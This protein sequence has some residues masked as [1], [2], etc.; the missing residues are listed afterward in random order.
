MNKNTIPLY[1]VVN[2]SL[3]V[4]LIIIA[5][6]QLFIYPKL[7]NYNQVVNYIVSFLIGTIVFIF[8][9]LF[10][11]VIYRKNASFRINLDTKKI[12]FRLFYLIFSIT[13]IL[14]VVISYFFFQGIL[15]N[16]D[17]TRTHN[18]LVKTI[19]EVDFS[20]CPLNTSDQ[21]CCR[22]DIICGTGYKVRGKKIQFF[23][24]YGFK[25][26][27]LGPRKWLYSINNGTPLL[28]LLQF[29]NVEVL[30]V[31]NLEQQLYL[32]VRKDI[33]TKTLTSNGVIMHQYLGKQ[34][35]FG[36]ELYASYD[37][38]TSS[39]LLRIL[40]KDI[41]INNISS[42]Q[43]YISRSFYIIL[44]YPY[45]LSMEIL[46]P[47]DIDQA[48]FENIKRYNTNLVVQGTEQKN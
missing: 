36:Q 26:I 39:L 21:G 25:N 7:L 22:S 44:D 24:P 16:I 29:T 3:L 5:A 11:Q 38:I 17:K 23:Y 6:S 8:P 42:Q 34:I 13:L 9:Y 31:P 46:Y 40:P 27:S 1:A 10:F 35:E 43:I 20:Y 33:N 37:E 32:F 15:Q 19:K 2:Y 14:T 4:S 28:I 45:A 18:L 41:Y 48:F 12:S 47:K 30:K